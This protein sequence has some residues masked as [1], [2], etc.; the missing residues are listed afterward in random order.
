MKNV[1]KYIILYTVS[2]VSIVGFLYSINNF[3]THNL[4]TQKQ[5]LIKQAQTHFYDQINT[6]KWNAGYGGVYVLPKDGQ[7]PNPYL[8]NNILKTDDDKTLIKINPA[9]M[10]RQLS[11]T[12][13]MKEYHFRIT[14]LK[15]INPK[16]K[17]DDFEKKALE[18]FEQSGKK[19]YYEFVNKHE[20]RYMGALLVT[21][22]CMPCHKEQGY[23][24]GDIRGGI[25]VTLD[26]SEYDDITSSLLNRAF[27]MKIIITL[28]ILSITLLIYR[29]L[30]NSEHL[31]EIVEKRTKEIKSTQTLLQEVL[32]ADLSLLVVTDGKRTIFTN[33]TMLNFFEMNSLEEFKDKYKCVSDIFNETDAQGFLSKTDAQQWIEFIKKEHP[34]HDLKVAIRKDGKDRYFTPHA[35]EIMVDDK[36]LYLIIFDEITRQYNEMKQLKEKAAKDSLTKLFNRGKFEDILSNEIELCKTSM[37]TLSIIFLDID[38]FKNVNDTLGHDVGD[39]VLRELAEIIS[40]TVRG[41]D[42]VAR[43]GGEEFVITLHNTTKENALKLAE[44]LRKKVEDHTFKT[45]GKLTI[46]LG[47]TEYRFNE[48]KESFTKRMDQALYE[49]KQNGR[50]RVVQH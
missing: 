33:K 43:W 9:W 27:S 25:S 21:K 38:F 36:A 22:A 13:S 30:K 14:S 2:F 11:E 18:Y 15:P 32:D 16:N 20:F 50:N 24:I 49:A 17:P 7:K 35:K 1:Y 8:K 31:Q 40:S 48:T 10:T 42:F 45:A 41:N 26:A 4:D 44:K 29:Q 19:E 5:I 28:F 34:F 23:K 46:S 6:R 3:L 37:C 39:E 47:V 12:E